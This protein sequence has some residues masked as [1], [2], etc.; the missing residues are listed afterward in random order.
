MNNYNPLLG[1]W[2]T[3]ETEKEIREVWGV[4]GDN[5]RRLKALSRTALDSMATILTPHQKE[6]IEYNILMK[7]TQ[8]ETARYLGVKP[9][10]VCR[11][12]K[13]ALE[14]MQKI[15]S[16]SAS[17]LKYYEQIQIE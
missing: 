13:A 1:E 6:V 11:I 15:L 2:V 3:R 12:R 14:K 8:R 16:L 17:A 10:T 5:Q 7:H 4:S 9:C